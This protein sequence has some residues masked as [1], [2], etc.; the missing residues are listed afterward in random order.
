[1][2]ILHRKKKLNYYDIFVIARKHCPRRIVQSLEVENRGIGLAK[3]AFTF[4]S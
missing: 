4:C 3:I 1:M 2:H